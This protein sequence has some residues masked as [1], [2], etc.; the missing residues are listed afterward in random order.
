VV[1][2]L[3]TCSKLTDSQY[4]GVL[5]LLYKSGDREM[6]RNW[7]PITLLNIDYKLISK[8]FSERL[9][10]VLPNIIHTDQKG[11]VKGRY[12]HEANRHI[13]DI[14]NYVDENNHEG[15]VVYLDQTKAFDRVEWYWIDKC[16]EKFNFSDNVRKNST[17]TKRVFVRIFPN[18]KV[19]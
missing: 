16:L 12:I 6:L 1:T 10:S 2:E 19:D 4:R 3:L 11:Y 13:Q 15:V 7:R 18:V 8:C 14:I 17:K 5:S 9:K